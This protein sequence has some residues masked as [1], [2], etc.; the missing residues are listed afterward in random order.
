MTPLLEEHG[1]VFNKVWN[2][3]ICRSCKEGLP[4]RSIPEHLTASELSRWDK[5]I[6][7]K[8]RTITNHIPV[9]PM[10][11]R[12]AAARSFINQLA[13]SLISDGYIQSKDD[14]LDAASIVE[15]V[16][17][18]PSL[19]VEPVEG[20]AV[21]DGWVNDSNHVVRNKRGLSSNKGT[22]TPIMTKAFVQTFT[23][24][25][26]K[27]F[28]VQYIQKEELEEAPKQLML[29]PMDLLHL[30]KSRLLS[31]IPALIQ[32]STDRRALLPIFVDSGIENWLNQFDRSTLSSQFPHCPTTGKNSTPKSYTRLAKASL[33][34]FGEDIKA[35]SDG[36]HSIR[37]AITNATP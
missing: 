24:T 29:Q 36:H 25:Y 22:K 3:M 13:Q 30:E 8:A 21:F 5:S 28:T 9:P 4:L 12:S 35:L 6:G 7:K 19:P 26:P 34:L 31:G 11:V 27:L 16:A 2:L 33:I 23:E 15:W 20:I 17:K 14:I 10:K 1:L 18:F 37:H 32:S